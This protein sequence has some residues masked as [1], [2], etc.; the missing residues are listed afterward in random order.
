M[1]PAELPD[2]GWPRPEGLRHT[3]IAHSARLPPSGLNRPVTGTL[4]F[5]DQSVTPS[6]CEGRRGNVHDDS[7]YRDRR[8]HIPG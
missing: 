8:R 4:A 7:V 1:D 2:G 5:E 6:I 3:V